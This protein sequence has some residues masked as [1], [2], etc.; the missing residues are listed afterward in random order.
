MSPNADNDAPPLGENELLA[1]L[2]ALGVSHE[3]HSHS[4]AF[5]V[6]ES[7]ALRGV[8]PGAHVKNLFL[9][10]KKKRYWLVTAAEDCVIDLKALRKH[11]GATGS[12]SFGA[13]DAL[14]IMLG[15]TPGS[16]TPFGVINDRDGKVSVVL[17]QTLLKGDIVNAHPLRN[18]RTTALH[19]DGLM[20]FLKAENHPPRIVNFTQLNAAPADAPLSEA[21]KAAI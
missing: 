16:V 18:D 3:T 2:D 10:D 11:I 5:T 4:P 12:L 7:Q 20:R 21:A 8:L 13:P 15:V 19:P 17:D 6:D 9:R 14:M 1:R